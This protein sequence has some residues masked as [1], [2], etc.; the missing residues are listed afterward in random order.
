MRRFLTDN[1]E[2]EAPPPLAEQDEVGIVAGRWSG[3]L[4]RVA[5]GT[6]FGFLEG[7]RGEDTFIHKNV[8]APEVWRWLQDGGAVTF[9]VESFGG[10]ERACNVAKSAIDLDAE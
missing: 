2:S 3:T 9:D 5:A 4:R 6:S 10:R 1:F 7:S 8:V